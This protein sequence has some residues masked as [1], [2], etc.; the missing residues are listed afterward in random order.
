MAPPTFVKFL[1]VD[2]FGGETV[3]LK[4]LGADGAGYSAIIAPGAIPATIAALIAGGGEVGAGTPPGKGRPALAQPLLPSEVGI[5]NDEA[6]NPIVYFRF[7]KAGS[8]PVQLTP[9]LAADLRD[10]VAALV[11]QL[12]SKTDKK[13]H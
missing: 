2:V 10:K 4:F 1:G 3:K 11:R 5:G 7:G 13:K 9:E 12:Q 8:L 6:G